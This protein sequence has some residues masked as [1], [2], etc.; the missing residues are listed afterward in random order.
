[1]S[2][3]PTFTPRFGT[4]LLIL[5]ATLAGASFAR[6]GDGDTA[7]EPPL[8]LVL[9]IDGKPIEVKLDAPFKVDVNG[10]PTK[11]KLSAKPHRTLNIDG[12]QLRYPSAFTF[13]FDKSDPTMP[14]WSVSGNDSTISVA[15]STEQGTPAEAI[16]GFVEGFCGSLQIPTPKTSDVT[17]KI[18]DTTARGQQF[19]ATLFDVLRQR[20]EV[21]AFQHGRHV[22]LLTIQQNLNDSGKPT[23]ESIRAVR[24]LRESIALK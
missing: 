17:L 3:Y 12:L 22:Y 6:A 13:E 7:A 21:Y 24:M 11:M 19:E 5:T 20:I 10:K 9:E 15:R 16:D 1:M 23:E 8:E 2:A 14:Q 4:I 18:G